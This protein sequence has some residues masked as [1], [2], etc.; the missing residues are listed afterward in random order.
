M[1]ISKLKLKEALRAELAKLEKTD[2]KALE[3]EAAKRR[4]QVAATLVEL[5]A[6]IA[7]VEKV[8]DL[9][10]E[11]ILKAECREGDYRNNFYAYN[12]ENASRIREIRNA[13][14]VLEFVTDDSVSVTEANRMVGRGFLQSVMY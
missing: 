7:K 4:K 13:L 14:K 3:G 10:D 1:K 2:A 9:S 11:G 12:G 5:K 8:G 6:R